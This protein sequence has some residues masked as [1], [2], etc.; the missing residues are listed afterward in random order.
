MPL[1]CKND[2]ER[3]LSYYLESLLIESANEEFQ[4]EVTG[5]KGAITVNR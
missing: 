5:I 3:A 1:E 4:V 2:L